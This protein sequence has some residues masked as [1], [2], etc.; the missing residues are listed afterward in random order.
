MEVFF[1]VLRQM[2]IMFTFIAIGFV[3]RKASLIPKSSSSVISKLETFVFVPCL[4]LFTMLTK[5]T[6]ENF[7]ANYVLI[8][9]GLALL[10]IALLIAYP[11]S[12]LFSRRSKGDE[13]KEYLRNIYKYIL[14]FG[15]FCVYNFIELKKSF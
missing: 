14:T 9:Y 11:L 3:L 2:L 1:L 6:V 15:N 4:N 5:C 7:K 10:L 8:F 13:K 12:R